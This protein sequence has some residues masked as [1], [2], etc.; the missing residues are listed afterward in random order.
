MRL[1]QVKLKGQC[2]MLFVESKLDFIS[3]T[4]NVNQ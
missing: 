1:Y 2:L 4:S 3:N